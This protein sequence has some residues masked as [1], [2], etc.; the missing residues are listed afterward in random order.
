MPL[1]KQSIQAPSFPTSFPGGL[2]PPVSSLA[3]ALAGALVM[4]AGG[5]A[6]LRSLWGSGSGRGG[7]RGLLQGGA[8]DAQL[9]V[10]VGGHNACC[11]FLE[12]IIALFFWTRMGEDPMYVD[13]KIHTIILITIIR[14]L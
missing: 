8:E 10:Q 14:Y 2:L 13:S 5:A 9:S 4:L 1:A 6:L 7:G 12:A 3:V 11:F